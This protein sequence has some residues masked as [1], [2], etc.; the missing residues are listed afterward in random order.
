MYSQAENPKQHTAASRARPSA[1]LLPDGKRA[2]AAFSDNR[3]A[4]SLQKQLAKDINSKNAQS[5]RFT[6]PPAGKQNRQPEARLPRPLA[7]KTAGTAK[8]ESLQFRLMSEEDEADILETG[9]IAAKAGLR[10]LASRIINDLSSEDRQKLQKASVKTYGVPYQQ[11]IVFQS[12]TNL[13]RLTSLIRGLFPKTVFAGIEAMDTLPLESSQEAKN[14]A[15]YVNDGCAI[16][17]EI[18]T[19]TKQDENLLQVFWNAFR[20]S[21]RKI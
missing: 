1:R 7:R 8:G 4:A 14:L 18:G 19:T 6:N 20:E 12:A 11:F 17:Q 15:R 2:A 9:G 10:K 3:Q 13:K 21:K 5:L 16:L